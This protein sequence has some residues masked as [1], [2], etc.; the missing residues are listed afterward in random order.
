MTR[1]SV[2]G[3][4]FSQISLFPFF[5]HSVFSLSRTLP[6]LFSA[7]LSLLS[8]FFVL[9]ISTLVCLLF[10]Y[11]LSPVFPY[12]LSFLL[13]VSLSASFFI[14]FYLL[15]P[16]SV[17]C[18]VS[19]FLCIYAKLRKAVINFVMSVLP[20]VHPHGT[21]RLPLDR[22]LLTSLSDYFPKVCREN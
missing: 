9:L 3:I 4:N 19:F 5:L 7:C 22:C 14:T 20:S 8:S 2:E 12:F 11:L 10:S 1:Y 21:T 13:L 17:S 6:L 18:F 15:S 16:F